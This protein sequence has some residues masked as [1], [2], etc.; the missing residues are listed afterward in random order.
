M[1]NPDTGPNLS[2]TASSS[3][4]FPL[5]WPVFIG[6]VAVLL[7]FGGFGV[8]AATAPISGAA[9]A[10]GTLVATG[11]NKIVQHLEGGTIEDILVGEGET[12]ELGQPLIV[13]DQTIPETNLRR[14][15][16]RQDVQRAL[17][18]RLLSERDG[19]AT[20]RFPPELADNADRPDVKRLLEDQE[21]EFLARLSRHREEIQVLEKQVRAFTE[22]ITGIRAQNEA[23]EIQIDLL[24]QEVQ[25][26]SSLIEEGLATQERFLALKRAQASLLGNR[27][28]NI[29][30]IAKV[31]QQIAQT[32]RQIQVVKATR[33]EEASTSLVQIRAN[34]QD[35][36]A[37]LSTAA[38][39]LER[40]VVRAPTSGTIIKMNVHTLGEII[41]SG[42]HLMEILP[43]GAELLIE[44]RVRPEDI[45]V[46][47]PEKKATIMFSALNRQT[48]PV[49]TAYVQFV[50]ADRLVD[51]ATQQP[52]YLA[53]LKLSEED[54][55]LPVFDSLYPGMQV[56][57]FIQTEDRTFIDYLTRPI[58]DSFR[59]AFRES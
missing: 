18:A 41:R 1:T 33:Q 40:I 22:E 42:Q 29:A 4:S 14:L 57:A 24:G 15:R 7:F 34:I 54:S 19:S 13:L 16:E 48:T 44:A 6:S 38:D 31:R 47:A 3:R 56:E 49:A 2:D 17:E 26:I 53:R 25:S 55:R 43:Q 5:K 28:G 9:V 11:Q 23:L 8:W 37:Q 46:V 10:V 12:V 36:E 58:R 27:G 45:D 35:I 59:K 32:E 30:A 51:E 52:Y 50:S 39:T 21:A 20:I